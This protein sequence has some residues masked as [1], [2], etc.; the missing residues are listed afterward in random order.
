MPQKNL[1]QTVISVSYDSLKTSAADIFS[2]VEDRA[3][4]GGLA[5]F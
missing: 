2:V 1:Y 5:H 4:N 3:K